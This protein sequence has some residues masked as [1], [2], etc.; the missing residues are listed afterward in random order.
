MHPNSW[1]TE[2]MAFVLQPGITRNNPSEAVMQDVVK[3]SVPAY[4]IISLEGYSDKI[5]S[6][7]TY[8]VNLQVLKSP[9]FVITYQIRQNENVH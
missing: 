6:L 8:A 2:I 9:E 4:Y 7:Y 5:I 1:Q 3:L